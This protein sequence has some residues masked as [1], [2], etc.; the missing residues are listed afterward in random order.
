MSWLIEVTEGLKKILLVEE[1]LSKLADKYEALAGAYSSI[2][3]RLA[4]LEGKFELLEHIGTPQRRK[5][6]PPA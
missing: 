4:R 5:R 3:Q 2:N 1:R 6:L